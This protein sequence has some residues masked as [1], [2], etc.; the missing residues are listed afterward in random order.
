MWRARTIACAAIA[1]L[2]VVA[3]SVHADTLPEP[4][5][6]SSAGATDDVI[7]YQHGYAFLND[8]KYPPD[9]THFDYVNPDA[10]KGGQMRIPDLGTWDTFTDLAV[11]GRF[12]RGISFWD[13]QRNHLYD[14]LLKN[15]LDEPVAR[16]GWL[17][18]PIALGIHYAFLRYREA[19]FPKLT[20]VLHAGVY[21]IL[22][23]LIACEM[24]WQVD[25]VASGVWPRAV[26]IAGVA[27]FV[28]A[29][30]RA[31]D[32]L[33]WPVARH[34]K[35]YSGACVGG[36]LLVTLSAVIGNNLVSPGDPAPL[37]YLPVL[38]P[39]A[40]TSIFTLF[41]TWR[42][43]LVNRWWQEDS[44]FAGPIVAGICLFLLTMAVARGVHHW[45]GVPFDL[46]TLA[47][48]V[49]LQTSLSMVWGV[50]GLLGMVLGAR[51][52]RREIWIGGAALMA[53]VVIKLFLVELGNTGTVGRVVS[54]L[55]VGVLLLI[56]GYFAPAPPRLEREA[57]AA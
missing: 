47:E 48:S 28:L 24:N 43:L 27:F 5:P 21:W 14:S 16:Y 26:E 49:V 17:A 18:W 7:D 31:R 55:G 23:A 6:Q 15:S 39:L 3:G 19:Q 2:C 41:V 12:V 11:R 13:P 53:V 34:W 35:A 46:E 37:P 10:P 8:L 56:V 4:E 40:L 38:N 1:L 42:W 25:Q 51:F 9:F 29:T 36:V 50:T 44:R 52:I 33:S 45:A 20:M 30:L 54:F 22:A 32:H 57:E